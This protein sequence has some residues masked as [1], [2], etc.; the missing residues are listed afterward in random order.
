MSKTLVQS[1]FKESSSLRKLGEAISKNQARTTLSG[2]HG[3]AFSIVVAQLFKEKDLPFLCVFNDKEE[4][5][6][7]LN[8]LEQ[9]VG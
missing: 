7:H 3:S 4:A 1:V 2:L 8:D 6:Y 5:A 9:L